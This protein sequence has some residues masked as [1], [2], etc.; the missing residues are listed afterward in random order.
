MPPCTSRISVIACLLCLS[1]GSLQ[2]S[3]AGESAPTEANTGAETGAGIE[4][5]A[6][7]GSEAGDGEAPL[8]VTIRPRSRPMRD[9]YMQDGVLATDDGRYFLYTGWY[10]DRLDD[11]LA[12]GS[13]ADRALRM[14][15]QDTVL[16]ILRAR[17]PRRPVFIPDLGMIL[18][19]RYRDMSRLQIAGSF[20][21]YL[22]P[23]SFPGRGLYGPVKLD[24]PW[25]R[26]DQII[27]RV[28]L[29]GSAR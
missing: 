26:A 18:G 8:E 19:G 4:A 27:G 3:H 13:I 7:A 5:G 24:A 22:G 23:T 1:A 20:D 17:P 16:E 28:N 10:I 12:P 15:L 21:F 6:A 2:I 14:G 11:R 29:S 9:G 25:S